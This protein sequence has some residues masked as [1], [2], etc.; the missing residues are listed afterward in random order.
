MIERTIHLGLSSSSR[1]C[2]FLFC[3]KQMYA[4]LFFSWKKNIY[5]KKPKRILSV[6]WEITRK[7]IYT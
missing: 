1:L 3:N 2:I 7:K 5:A 4:I 6:E